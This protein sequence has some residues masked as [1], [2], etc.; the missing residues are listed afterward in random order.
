[1]LVLILELPDADED[2]LEME[3]LV[4]LWDVVTE[5]ETEELEDPV[6]ELTAVEEVADDEDDEPDPGTVPSAAL[7]TYLVL[8]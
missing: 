7:G 4:E 5:V 3:L 2:E 1:M 6:L 8:S